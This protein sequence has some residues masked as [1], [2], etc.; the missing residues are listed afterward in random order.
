MRILVSGGAGFIGSHVADAYVNLGHQV[1]LVDNLSRG[2]RRNLNSR[3]HFYQ[4]D[5]RDAAGLDRVFAEFKP[6]V[7]N[8]HAAQM[9]VR[10]A[11]REPLLDATI[12]ILG[13]LN[14]LEAARRYRIRHFIYISTAGAG[15]GEPEQLPVAESC[16]PNPITP[17]GV[18]KHTVEHYLY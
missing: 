17:Y 12:N 9:D 16:P 3:A 18:S 13:S 2:F 15:Y 4:Q 8:H 14:L 10:L 6:E 1:A 7:I 5:I 11:V